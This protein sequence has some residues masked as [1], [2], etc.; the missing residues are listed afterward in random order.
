MTLE[1]HE[2]RTETV[3]WDAF[4]HASADGTP[5]HLTAWKRALE[6]TFGH[7]SFYLMAQRGDALE[8]VLPLFE[9]RGL[10]GGRALVSVPYAVYGGICA[11]SDEARVRL[12][13]AAAA[14]GRARGAAYVELRH[15]RDQGLDLPTKSLYV[16]FSRPIADDD[17]ANARA[18][19][20]KQRRMTRQGAKHGLRTEIGRDHLDGFYEIYARNLRSLGTPVFPRRL[21]HT[22]LETFEKDCRIV[23][24]WRGDEMLAGV[25]T[26]FYEDQVLPYYGA[27]RADAF[28]YAPND[29][30]YWELMRYAARA[31]HR[32][33]DFGRSREG[34]GSYHFKRHWGFE[35]APL[36]YQYVLLRRQDLPNLSPANP[37]VRLAMKAWTR[38]PFAVTKVLGPP[39][40][41]YLP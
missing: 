18:I 30:M 2:L 11:G 5:F 22:L 12:L 24:V 41:R 28:A 37:R 9:V 8:G 3:E 27:A 36:P 21:F 16:S 25:L 32:V 35:P 1:I 7:R 13:Q 6:A 38:L 34:S 40:T 26:I 17:E 23:T 15:R 20:G 14:L 10:F 4:V 19:P 31:G 39:L 33:F 29:F